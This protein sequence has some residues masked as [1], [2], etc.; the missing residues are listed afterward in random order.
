MEGSSLGI[1][2]DWES[3]GIE[4]DKWWGGWTGVDY[5]LGCGERIILQDEMIRIIWDRW[6]YTL[7]NM[8]Y[9]LSTNIFQ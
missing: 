5:I 1:S 9:P 6:N 7:N 3:F 2:H 8:G 4:S